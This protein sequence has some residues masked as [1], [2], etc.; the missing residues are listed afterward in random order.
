[1]AVVQISRIQHRSGVNE[2]LPQLARGEIGLSVDTRQV[3]IGNGGSDAPQI[4][5]LEI[6]T[7]RSDVLGIADTYTYKD[8]QIGFTAQTG[9]SANTPIT[10]TLQQKLDDF[11][12]VRDYGAVGDGTTDDTTAINRALNDLFCKETAKRT[13]RALYFPGGEYLVTD[14]IN[15]PTYAKLIGEGPDSTIIKSTDTGFGP[16]I[17]TA[18]SKQ[19]TFASIA[20]NAAVAP[21]D[22][23]IHGIS[24]EATTDISVFIV[25]QTTGLFV[26]NCNFKGNT[27]S[28]PNTIGTAVPAIK[29]TSSN[30]GTY[31]TSQIIFRNCTVSNKQILVNLDHD[32]RNIVFDSCKFHTAYKGVKVGE[33]I[34][35][36]APSVNGPNSVKVLNSWFYNI[37]K[38]GI[39]VYG[40]LHFSS[41]FNT[42]TTVA[43]DGLG[44]GNASTHVINFASNNCQSFGDTFTRPDADETSTT[45]RINSDT[46]GNKTFALDQSDGMKVGRYVRGYGVTA[47]LNNNTTASTGITFADNTDESVVEI[48][49]A[50][51]RNS[52]YR[53]G[54]MRITH[55][56]SAQVLD[57]DYNENN[58][59]TGVTFAIANAANVSTINYTTDNQTGGT[60]YYSVRFI[61]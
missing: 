7:S 10:R 34:T 29:L 11:A 58:G 25:D 8:D 18:D 14:T 60:L 39:H 1:M 12:N 37:Y 5:N 32:M 9:A 46:V 17:L 40:G 47:V 45:K 44:T 2:S 21:Q 61:R 23:V 16:V 54:R 27:S 55:D 26:E 53:Q 20:S 41:A 59:S 52:K 13:R 3:Y 48:D 24:W 15:V 31:V 19:Q 35:G 57:D 36:L 49:Y 50:I 33:T 6:L 56:S 43:E 42:F 22:I 38:E 30:S 51:L 28:I 4:E